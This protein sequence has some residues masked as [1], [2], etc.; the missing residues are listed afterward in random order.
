[1]QNLQ[2]PDD[3]ATLNVFLQLCTV[4]YVVHAYLL[5][6]WKV[7]PAL[8]AG[9]CCVLKPSELASVTCLEL[10]ELALRA[11]LPP[12]VLNVVTGLGPDAGAPLRW[13]DVFLCLRGGEGLLLVGLLLQRQRDAV[14]TPGHHQLTPPLLR[15]L[16]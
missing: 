10:A 2:E 9:N 7:A 5:L 4:T 13:A 11:G 15:S 8:A 6:Q 16:V 3:H 1:M 14:L 12:G